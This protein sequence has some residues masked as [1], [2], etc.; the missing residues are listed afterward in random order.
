MGE[1]WNGE[2]RHVRLYEWLTECEAW[3]AHARSIGPRALPRVQGPLQQ[4]REQRRHRVQAAGEMERALNCR[5]RPADRASTGPDRA[6]LREGFSKPGH[7][8]WKQ[9]A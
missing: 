6:R 5:D 4:Q 3:R 1:S 7:F 9:R 2:P 8:D